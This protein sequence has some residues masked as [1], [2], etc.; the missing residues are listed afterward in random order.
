MSINNGDGDAVLVGAY[1]DDERRGSAYLFR[2]NQEDG[3]SW[4]QTMKLRADDVN[5][6]EEYANQVVL[7]GNRAFV[8]ENKDGDNSHGYE[9]GAAHVYEMEYCH[10]D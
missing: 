7:D 1:H 4:T 8:G 3:T 2:R 6:V 10:D 9:A 5:A